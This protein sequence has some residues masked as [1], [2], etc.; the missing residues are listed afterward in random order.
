MDLC[1]NS[2]LAIDSIR[3]FKILVTFTVIMNKAPN[4]D[5]LTK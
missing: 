5:E 4:P 2:D 3:L 1:C